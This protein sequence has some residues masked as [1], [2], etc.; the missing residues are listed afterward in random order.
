VTAL[1]SKLIQMEV[2]H[3]GTWFY[4]IQSGVWGGQSGTARCLNLSSLIC[5]GECQSTTALYGHFIALQQALYSRIFQTFLQPE[6]HK[7]IFHPQRNS[8]V[9]KYLQAREPIGTF[10][11]HGN[12]SNIANFW[13]KISDILRGIVGIFLGISKRLFIYLTLCRGISNKVLHY[14]RVPWIQ[15]GKHC[16]IILQLTVTFNKT[17]RKC[18]V[19][20]NMNEE[21]CLKYDPVYVVEL[22]LHEEKCSYENG[23][24]S[25]FESLRKHVILS[26]HVLKFYVCFSAAIKEQCP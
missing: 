26:M 3:G 5:S 1:V 14:H 9:R 15:L 22:L 8:H 23:K 7:I 11:E 19:T 20:W 16:Y 24:L 18:I 6:T 12:Q 13:A 17:L 21:K 10:V 4:S 25:E 2:L